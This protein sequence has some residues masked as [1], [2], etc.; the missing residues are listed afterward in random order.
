MTAGNVR[1]PLRCSICVKPDDQVVVL[2]DCGTWFFICDECVDACSVI[3]AR[4]RAEKLKS[5]TEKCAGCLPEP[6]A[7]CEVLRDG[8]HA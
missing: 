3:V 5:E 8:A 4:H 6:V 1:K 2:I 7:A